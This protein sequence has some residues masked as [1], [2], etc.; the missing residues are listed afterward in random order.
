V[1]F[2][3][4]W[5]RKF[6]PF[7][8]ASHG[9]PSMLATASASTGVDVAGG[10]TSAY[11]Y[12][13]YMFSD[14]KLTPTRI[15]P[16]ERQIFPMA[17]T[18]FERAWSL[19]CATGAFVPVVNVDYYVVGHIGAVSEGFEKLF[20][21]RGFSRGDLDSIVKADGLFTSAM[22]IQTAPDLRTSSRHASSG[23]GC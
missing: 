19:L 21:P 17:S 13:A 15:S 8:L 23:S 10:I 2:P 14:G 5:H 20:V 9:S 7:N 1:S 11:S 4:E 3:L 18:E 12:P 16:K 22:A 6:L